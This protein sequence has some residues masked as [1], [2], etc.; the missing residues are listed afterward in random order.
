[1]ATTRNNLSSHTLLRLLFSKH[2]PP[3]G[4]LQHLNYTGIV[5]PH[6]QVLPLLIFYTKSSTVRSPASRQPTQILQILRIWSWSYETEPSGLGKQ[7]KQT[8][9]TK[10]INNRTEPRTDCLILSPR[11]TCQTQ[12]LNGN[13]ALQ[14][15]SH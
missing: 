13:M 7:S 11:L 5:R 2:Y 10:Q 6:Q 8:E 14:T 12:I 1:M 9:S 3:L 4:I 15:L